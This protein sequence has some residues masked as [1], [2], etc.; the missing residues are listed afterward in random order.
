MQ[1]LSAM[2]ASRLS[3]PNFDYLIVDLSKNGENADKLK[4]KGYWV[5]KMDYIRGAINRIVLGRNKAREIML[6]EDYDFLFNIDA[7]TIVPRYSL[8][9]M[10]SHNKDCI[11]YLCSLGKTL[12]FP[13]V[14]KSGNFY[15]NRA[16][17]GLDL[18][19]WQEIYALMP[20]LIKCHGATLGL[21]SRKVMEKIV[22]RTIPNLIGEDILFYNQCEEEGFE[23]YCDLGVKV[24]HYSIPWQS[25]VW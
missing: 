4:S 19:D 22:Y 5:E 7:D 1:E 16:Y 12:T 15:R 21:T 9:R 17:I 13:C 3:Y 14:F 18:Y 8:E 11:G 20:N 6:N 25:D 2:A 23:F 24:H 10:I